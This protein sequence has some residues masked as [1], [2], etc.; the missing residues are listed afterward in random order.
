MQNQRKSIPIATSALLFVC[1]MLHAQAGLSAPAFAPY[2]DVE[3]YSA[4][5]SLIPG[6]WTITA[7]QAR[8]LVIQAQTSRYLGSV[9]GSI[10]FSPIAFSADN[11]VATCISHSGNKLCGPGA[12]HGLERN[13]GAS[14]NMRWM[15]TSRAWAS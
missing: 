12:F 4:Y 7:A 11:A 5:Q 14:K 3:A 6:G 15:G 2:N 13:D 1:L 8:R 9:R 10:A